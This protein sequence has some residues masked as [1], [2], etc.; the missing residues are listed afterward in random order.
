M[1][2][3]QLKETSGPDL[4]RW[5]GDYDIPVDCWYQWNI[6]PLTLYI[7]RTLKEWRFAWYQGANA[8]DQTVESFQKI[9][10]VPD[11]QGFQQ[12]RFV[13]NHTSPTI[14]FGLRLA[15]RSVV[16]RPDVPLLIPA[17]ES[18]TLFIST[19][20]WLCPSLQGSALLELPFYRA[21]DTWF[22]QD[23]CSG[24]LCYMSKSRART[25]STESV[26]YPHRA[27]TEI[28]VR[29]NSDATVRLDRIRVPV[30]NLSL[31]K[32]ERGQFQSD[33]LSLAVHTKEKETKMEILENLKNADAFTLVS[34]P[35]VLLESGIIEQTFAKLF[36]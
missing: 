3:G 14:D 8:L 2:T 35:R 17:G 9:E 30:T 12:S 32:D 15:N 20:L 31:Y 26:N 33:S 22:G 24:E 11:L 21:S 7:Q 28:L 10:S 23:T 34:A 4:G 36:E 18:A 1:V 27:V 13:F 25:E 5:W 29:N 6:G 16:V 19:G